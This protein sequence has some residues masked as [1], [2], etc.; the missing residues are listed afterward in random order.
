MSFKKVC[1]VCGRTFHS[2]KYSSRFCSENCYMKAKNWAKETRYLLEKEGDGRT[3]NQLLYHKECLF[4]GLPFTARNTRAVYCS[5]RCGKLHRKAKSDAQKVASGPENSG[6][7]SVANPSASREFYISKVC[8]HCGKEFVAQRVTTMFC[9]TNCARK[10]RSRQKLEDKRKRV[11]E[12]TIRQNIAARDMN[13]P[14]SEYIRMTD[15]AAFLGVSKRTLM[16]YMEQGIIKSKKLPRV[17]LIEKKH[18]REL[19]ASDVSYKVKTKVKIDIPKDESNPV[20]SGD[21]MTITEAATVYDVPLNVMQH[22]LRR[23]DLKFVRYRNT[24][25]YKKDEVDGL[26][27]K[28]IKDRHPE[29]TEW[30]S[31]EDILSTFNITFSHLNG[32]LYRSSVP[33]RKDGGKTYYSKVHIDQEFNYL[34]EID[35]YYTTEELAVKY[36]ADKRKIAKLVQRHGLPKITRGS[37]IYIEKEPFDHFMRLNKHT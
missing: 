1:K 37:K 10:Y 20:F 15:A 9:S 5:P 25:F 22:Y 23:S 36:G 13:S 33:K 28:R 26:V 34:L 31:V 18:L 17:T 32:F 16:R 3:L 35:K 6:F 14:D 29:I 11:T 30:Y 7:N 4:C 21:Y 27:M 12:E 2:A 24:R 19:L 8:A